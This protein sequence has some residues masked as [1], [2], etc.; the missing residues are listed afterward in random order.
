VLA[1]P[2]VPLNRISTVAATPAQSAYCNIAT[3]NRCAPRAADTRLKDNHVP[4]CRAIDVLL[5]DAESRQTLACMRAYAR[6][7]LRV[8]AVAC[9]SDAWWAPAF[10]SRWCSQSAV[11][12]HYARDAD[13]YVDALLELLDRQPIQMVL[14][15]HDGSIQAI[16]PRR[17]EIERRTALPLASESA[18]DIAISKARTLELATELRI[19]I[20]RSVRMDRIEDVARGLR[21]IG[22]PAVVKP[23]QSWVERD[24]LGTRLSSELVTSATEA[25]RSLE[26]IFKVGGSALLQQWLPG[27]REAVSVLYAQNRFWARVAQ[28]SHREWPVLGGVS[29]LCETIPLPPDITEQAERLVGAMALEGCSMVEFRRD[30]EGR[31]VLM[32]V[33]PRIGGSV[34]LPISAGVNFPQLLF[35][36]KV[37]GLLQEVTDYTVGK[38][39]RWLAGDIWNLKCVFDS[40]G[41]P[42]VPPRGRAAADF[43]LDFVR[44]NIDLDVIDMKDIRPALAE[45]NKIVLHHGLNR[46]RKLSP[47]NWLTNAGK[48]N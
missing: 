33:N 5:L 16:R 26:W 9:D 27:R 4:A 8:G 38:R 42:D 1:D 39:L 6:G 19:A 21:E 10:K 23:I 40:Q 28:V 14:P 15:A 13:G 7:G 20:P 44:P 34:A 41:Q 24:G 17:V 12:P 48:V 31:P 36:W 32:E 45:L 47:L 46:V 3:T 43:L 2:G 30:A 37:R 29:V 18:L 22:L 25:Q 35:D 11:V